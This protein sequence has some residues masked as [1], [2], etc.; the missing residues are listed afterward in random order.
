MRDL[1]IALHNRADKLDRKDAPELF[2]KLAEIVEV[3]EITPQVEKA[4][5]V[6]RRMDT[7]DS[8]ILV[9]ASPL[10]SPAAVCGVWVNCWVF[11][12]SEE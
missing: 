2:A 10:V 11:V 9:D 8:S 3:Q 5:A 7:P 1:L 6:A 4:I 12:G